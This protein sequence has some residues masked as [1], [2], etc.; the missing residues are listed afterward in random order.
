[1]TAVL[2][3]AAAFRKLAHNICWF[4]GVEAIPMVRFTVM[5]T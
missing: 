3:G 2:P 1:M 4:P 5:Q